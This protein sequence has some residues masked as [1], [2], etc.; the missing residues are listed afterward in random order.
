V[1]KYWAIV[2]ICR[3]FSAGLELTNWFILF[4]LARFLWS[5]LTVVFAVLADLSYPRLSVILFLKTYKQA[6]CYFHGLLNLC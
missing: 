3:Y 2:E 4:W 6:I 5:N 1:I